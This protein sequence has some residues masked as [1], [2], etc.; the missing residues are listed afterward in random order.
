MVCHGIV[1]EWSIS[2]YAV[3]RLIT[4]PSFHAAASHLG[5]IFATIEVKPHSTSCLISTL[6]ILPLFYLYD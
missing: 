2:R 6:Y 4:Q 3:T 1:L 5:L